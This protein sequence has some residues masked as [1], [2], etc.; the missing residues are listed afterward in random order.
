MEQDFN[1][2]FM[3]QLVEE[4]GYKTTVFKIQMERTRIVL[5]DKMALRVMYDVSKIEKTLSGASTE[6]NL[7]STGGYHPSFLDNGTYF[8]FQ[9][10]IFKQILFLKFSALSPSSLQYFSKKIFQI[11]FSKY[12]LFKRSI[13][14]FKMLIKKYVKNHFNLHNRSE[15]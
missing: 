3:T 15:P 6:F 10:R 8:I 13:Y 2:Y 4:T 5:A 1:D 14:I 9:R 7:L 11:T 12:I